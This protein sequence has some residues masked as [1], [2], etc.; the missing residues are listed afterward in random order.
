MTVVTS[1][2]SAQGDAWQVE[3]DEAG[4]GEPITSIR[5][6]SATGKTSQG[7]YGDRSVWPERRLGLYTG[8]D[9]E[10]GTN[11]MIVRVSRDV[12]SVRVRLHP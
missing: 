12:A 4:G 1:G 10:G 5:V 8:W 3:V 11:R 9:D 6:D 2:R 7:G